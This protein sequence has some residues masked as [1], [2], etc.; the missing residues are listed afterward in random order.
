MHDLLV[1]TSEPRTVLIESHN[2]KVLT[3]GGELRKALTY[4]KETLR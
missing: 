4:Q 3:G 2:S 1:Y